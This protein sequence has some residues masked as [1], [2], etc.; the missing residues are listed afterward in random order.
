MKQRPRTLIWLSSAFLAYFFYIVVIRRLI[1]GLPGM[2]GGEFSSTWVFY[3]FALLHAGYALGWRNTLIFFAI[4][5]VISWVFEQVGVATG[6][7]YGPYHYT[8]VLGAKLGHVP[9]II[10]IA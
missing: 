6:L 5:A 9:I 2:P 10:P 7:I 1:P 4:G 3:L 8:D